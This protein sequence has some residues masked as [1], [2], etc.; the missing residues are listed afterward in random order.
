MSCLPLRKLP[1]WLATISPNKV[2][3]ELREKVIAFQNEADDVLWAAWQEQHCQPTPYT[4]QPSDT[5]SEAQQTALRAMLESNVK[6]LPMEKRGEA[7]RQGWSKLKSHFKVPYRKIPASE[8][9]EALSIVARHVAQWEL[10]DE[11]AQQ[12]EPLPSAFMQS[13]AAAR[14]SAMA[15]LDGYRQA[16]QSGQSGPRIDEIPQHL[17]EGIVAEAL[18]SNRFL[19]SFDMRTGQMHVQLVPKDA[20]V[21]SFQNGD[22]GQAISAIPTRRLPELQ[23]ALSRRVARH[24]GALQH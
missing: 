18:M 9:T 6:R 8:F 3:P 14:E 2:R 12:P 21:F 7:M 4:V 17:L 19:A 10:V 1:G 11:T 20:S 23:D 24:L 16:V 15:Y 13:L 5:L 22:F